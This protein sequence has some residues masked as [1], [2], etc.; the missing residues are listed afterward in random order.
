MADPASAG[1]WLVDGDGV[2]R[3][4]PVDRWHGD[5]EPAVAGLVTR[6]AGPTLDLGCGPGRLTVALTRA[7]LTAVG[8]DVSAAAVRLTRARGAVA[9]RR[10]LFDPLPGEGR[11]AHAVLIDGNIGIGGDPVALLRRCRELLVPGGTVLV[12]LEPAGAGLWQGQARVAAAHRAGRLLL[13]PAFRW[14]RLDVHAVHPVAGAAGLGVR[15]LFRRGRR[16][17]GEL[18]PS[19]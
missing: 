16:W 8:V 3:S 14:A 9:L 17:F 1:R 5:A 6:C 19:R 15:Q 18:G 13:G 12:E 11:W 4:L 2:R 10:D 7:G